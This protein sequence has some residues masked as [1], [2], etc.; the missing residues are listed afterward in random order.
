MRKIIKYIFEFVK[1]GFN[2]LSFLIKLILQGSFKNT[3]KYKNKGTVAVLA[4]GPSLKSELLKFTTDKEFKDIDFIVLNF[5]A[6]EKSFFEIKPKYYCFADP[7]FFQD[8]NRRDDV[9]KLFSILE[10]LVDWDLNIHIPSTLYRKF[11]KFSKF[12][13]SHLII[14]KNNELTYAGFERYRHFFYKQGL[15]MPRVQTVANLAIFIALNGGY[16]MTKLYG[17]DHTFFDNL[18]IND[19]NQ[20]CSMDTHF[21]DH[22]GKFVL[23]PLLRND[24]DDIWKI[25]DYLEALTYMFKSHDQLSEYAKYLKV[26]ILNCTTC[27]MIDSYERF[28][29]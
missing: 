23:K 9:Y 2:F 3:L 6:F 25:S 7:M 21:Y 27:S 18:K 4:N 15:A 12:K 20:L 24:N 14:V 11:I 1:K 28:V 17:V 26:S 29:K 10:N 13:N 8:S 16:S 19:E 22:D 5:F